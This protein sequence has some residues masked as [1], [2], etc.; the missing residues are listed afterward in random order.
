LAT[1][2]VGK[3]PDWTDRVD[4][5]TPLVRGVKR[6][7]DSSYLSSNRESQPTAVLESCKHRFVFDWESSE[8]VCE[9]GCGWSVPIF[10]RK[11][12]VYASAGA[13]LSS[14]SVANNG[15]GTDIDQSIRE[16]RHGAIDPETGT[17]V[18]MLSGGLRFLGGSRSGNEDLIIELSNRLHGRVSDSDLAA[19]AAVFRKDLA[20]MEKR[21]RKEA[22]RLLDTLTGGGD[23][24][25]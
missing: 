2:K 25:G 22:L 11:E 15:L 16:L 19:I 7:R 1:T 10:E 13:R 5:A 6:V 21:K 8:M 24:H 4:K 23:G 14:P 17:R 9:R 18:Y 12:M 3:T 20:N